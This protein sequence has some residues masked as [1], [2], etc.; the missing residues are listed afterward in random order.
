M[1][2]IRKTLQPKPRQYF[3]PARLAPKIGDIITPDDIRVSNEI[4]A[5]LDEVYPGHLWMVTANHKQGVAYI[6]NAQIAANK[7]VLLHLKGPL[8][9]TTPTGLRRNVV[10]FCGE[11]LERANVRRGAYTYGDYGHLGM[12]P[13]KKV[14]FA[15]ID[16]KARL[17]IIGARG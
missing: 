4:G 10:K 7:G 5:I 14:D 2:I 6:T 17:T 1:E 13:E 16:D 12:V 8:A 15:D 9:D 11:L 3:D